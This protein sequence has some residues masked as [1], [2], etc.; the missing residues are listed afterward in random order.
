MRVRKESEIEAARTEADAWVGELSDRDLAMFA[1][2]LYAG[3]GSKT[4]GGIGFANSDPDLIRLFLRWL[5]SSFDID[6]SRLRARL[7]LHA[8]L[9]I[10]RATDFWVKQ[11]GI[12]ADQF[13]QPYRAVVDETMRH[14]RHV[15]GCL[16]VRYHS[17][18]LQRRVMAKIM[19]VASSLADPG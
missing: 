18:S 2:A 4:E 1:L 14:R 12:P 10:D 15:H 19:A 17:R 9:D 6:E 3:E 8:D 13:H 5:R 16:T 7:Y 11:T